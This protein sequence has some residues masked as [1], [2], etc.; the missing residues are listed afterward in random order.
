LSVSFRQPND[1]AHFRNTATVTNRLLDAYPNGRVSFV[2]PS[3][4]YQITGGRLKSQFSSDDD[5]Y[6]VLIV[7]VDLPANGAITISVDRKE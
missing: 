6:D 7:G 5:R 4:E 1:A 3:G 2:V